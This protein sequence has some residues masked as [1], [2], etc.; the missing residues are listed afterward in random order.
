M[1]AD[2][3]ANPENIRSLNL[4]DVH[5]I[6]NNFRKF[7][8]L[9]EMT[10]Y[11]K[12]PYPAIAVKLSV[13]IYT[14]LDRNKQPTDFEMIDSVNSKEKNT[15]KFIKTR[16][17]TPCAILQRSQ[18]ADSERSMLPP[19][20]RKISKAK[21]LQN[22][23]IYQNV[24]IQPD[25]NLAE[26][27]RRYNLRYERRRI[28]VENPGHSVYIHRGKIMKIIRNS[29]HR[30]QP[31][32]NATD[33]AICDE[34]NLYKKTEED[35]KVVS[36]MEEEN[37][38]KVDTQFAVFIC[39]YFNNKEGIDYIISKL[40]YILDPLKPSKSVVLAG[41]CNTRKDTSS[42]RFSL[43]NSILLQRGLTIC[44]NDISTYKFIDTMNFFS[45]LRKH[46]PV[47]INMEILTEYN[48]CHSD[49]VPQQISRHTRLEM[50][51][52]TKILRAE[53]LL[54][55]NF[56]DRSYNVLMSMI[57]EAC[58]QIKRESN[59]SVRRDKDIKSLKTKENLTAAVYWHRINFLLK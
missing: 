57:L 38:I 26:S 13:A 55:Q 50:L 35:L 18:L 20:G 25:Y 41:D 15:S 7:T 48:E 29:E 14:F 4:H 30:D 43:L 27:E 33:N 45:T 31:E 49:I 44:M 6:D 10:F 56:I 17:Q 42:S 28:Q 5:I 19:L 52:Y 59:K 1:Y 34:L 12:T 3:F 46:W 11:G 40:T 32:S 58:I 53:Y 22:I 9:E 51:Y 23:S 36:I 2:M 47:R 39:Y 16:Q 24:Y 37:Y 54:D 8:S 21:K